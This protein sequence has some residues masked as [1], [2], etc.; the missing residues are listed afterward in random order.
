MFEMMRSE[1]AKLG[2]A[3]PA[4]L[5]E[6][7][8]IHTARESDQERERDQGTG[9]MNSNRLYRNVHTDPN[10]G[11]GP[12]TIVSYCAIPVLRFNNYENSNATLV[13]S[14]DYHRVLT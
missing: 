3:C 6:S 7:W 5:F 1:S 12:D 9:S 8:Y 13:I 4:P 11:Q 10:Q 2:C 14:L